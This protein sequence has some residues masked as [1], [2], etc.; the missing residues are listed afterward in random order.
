VAVRSTA[1]TSREVDVYI[2]LRQGKANKQVADILIISMA[3]VKKRRQS[4][5]KKSGA[6]SISECV[7]L[8][9]LAKV[10]IERHQAMVDVSSPRQK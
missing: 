4:I 6:H 2:L 3:A 7:W 10:L 5:Y 8:R 1:L 9:E